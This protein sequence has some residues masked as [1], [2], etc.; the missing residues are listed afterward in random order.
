MTFKCRVGSNRLAQFRS[1]P[2]QMGIS[3]G[4]AWWTDSSES[5]LSCIFKSLP[6]TL[7]GSDRFNQLHITLWYHNLIQFNSLIH[8][9]LKQPNGCVENG[10]DWNHVIC[11]AQHCIVTIV[12][13]GYEL[14]IRIQDWAFHLI[15]NYLSLISTATWLG[16]RRPLGNQ[17]VHLPAPVDWIK[18][19]LTLNSSYYITSAEEGARINWSKII[20]IMIAQVFICCR[21]VARLV[22]IWTVGSSWDSIGP[23]AEIAMWKQ[24]QDPPSSIRSTSCWNWSSIRHPF[25]WWDPSVSW[26]GQSWTDAGK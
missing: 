1:N 10:S 24:P 9:C 25:R 4:S 7:W 15:S 22:I 20:G 17:S 3:I 21:C 14:S 5:H 8:P 2:R 23:H 19:W 11:V 12:G 13:P 6:C 16:R 26:F 18:R